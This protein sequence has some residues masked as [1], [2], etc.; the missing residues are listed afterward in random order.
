M[1]EDENSD[2][3]SDKNLHAIEDCLNDETMKNHFM[4]IRNIGA[5]GF[6]NVYS[7]KHR[8]D[9]KSNALKVVSINIEK[10]DKREV[11]VL[12]SLDHKNI[13]RY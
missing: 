5:G 10:F 6:G 1:M 7:A 8:I 2:E 4:D 3:S 9:S 11:E 13:I 12:S